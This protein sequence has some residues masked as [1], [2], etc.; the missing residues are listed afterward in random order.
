[1]IKLQR[2]L[3]MRPNE[4]FLMR[5]GDIETTRGNGLWYYVPG[6]YKT[7][8]FIGSIVFPLGEPEQKL[9]A[10]YLVGKKSDEAVLS[11]VLKNLHISTCRRRCRF[12]PASLRLLVFVARSNINRGG[13]LSTG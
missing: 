1:M 7:S 8:K 13:E 5:V 3:G 9:I 6:S 2:I 10:P 11:P 12:L 4:I